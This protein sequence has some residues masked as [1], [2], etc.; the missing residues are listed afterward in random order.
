MKQCNRTVKIIY[1]FVSY[2]LIGPGQDNYSKKPIENQEC[3]PSNASQLIL[4]Q[5]LSFPYAYSSDLYSFLNHSKSGISI[6]LT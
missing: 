2:S 5:T 3:P 4:I 1:N 6:A